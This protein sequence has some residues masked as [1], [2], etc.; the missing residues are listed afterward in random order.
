MNREEENS[1]IDSLEEY[2]ERELDAFVSRN[3][4]PWIA[5]VKCPCCDLLYFV[6]TRTQAL[7]DFNYCTKCGSKLNGRGGVNDHG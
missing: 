2:T 7:E 6:D 5:Q 3:S 4:K 1:F